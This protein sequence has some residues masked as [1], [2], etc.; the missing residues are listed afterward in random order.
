MCF[1]SGPA[2]PLLAPSELAGSPGEL[3]AAWYQ[4]SGFRL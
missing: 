3:A 2:G 4:L 1:R